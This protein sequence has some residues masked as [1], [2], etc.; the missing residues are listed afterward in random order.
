MRLLTHKFTSNEMRNKAIYSSN[1]PITVYF[2]ISFLSWNSQEKWTCRSKFEKAKIKI[3]YKKL[4]LLRIRKRLSF[5]LKMFNIFL[6]M[7]KRYNYCPVISSQSAANEHN[8]TAL[9][10]RNCSESSI[11]SENDR[12]HS[13]NTS[14]VKLAIT[15]EHMLLVYIILLI[16]HW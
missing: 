13:I 9:G 11:L 8:D 5:H 7:Y 6:K 10:Y 15:P 4:L 12:L 3:T 16:V 2:R 1:L 14:Y